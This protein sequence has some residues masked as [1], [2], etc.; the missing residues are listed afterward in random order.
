MYVEKLMATMN[1]PKARQHQMEILDKLNAIIK[2]FVSGDGIYSLIFT[3]FINL[4]KAD[5]V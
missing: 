1:D 3:A 4:S 5:T 2:K